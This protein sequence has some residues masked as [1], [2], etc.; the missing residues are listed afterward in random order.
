MDLCTKDI[1]FTTFIYS[2]PDN[3][4][5]AFQISRKGLNILNNS[6]SDHTTVSQIKDTYVNCNHIIYNS[7]NIKIIDE[8]QSQ[9]IS[10][11]KIY[12]HSA[13]LQDTIVKKNVEY[14]L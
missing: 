12:D 10:I 5:G 14:D 3:I 7:S 4:F 11:K 6:T 1:S 9:T 2:K 8:Y 13:F